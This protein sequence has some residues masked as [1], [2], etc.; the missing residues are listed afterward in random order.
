LAPPPPCSC[1]VAKKRVAL[2]AG[3]NH[4]DGKGEELV[5]V[6]GEDNDELTLICA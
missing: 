3:S 5:T 6:A 1:T 2:D 4:T